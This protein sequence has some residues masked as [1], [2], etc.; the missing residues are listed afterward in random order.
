MRRDC[1]SWRKRIRELSGNTWWFKSRSNWMSISST[2][3][4]VEIGSKDTNLGQ[5]H[6]RVSF[7][8]HYSSTCPISCAAYFLAWCLRPVISWGQWWIQ[9]LYIIQLL[10]TSL[11][12]FCGKSVICWYLVWDKDL[13]FLATSRINIDKMATL[14]TYF[15][16]LSLT[17]SGII[18]KRRN[19]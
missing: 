5:S 12:G 4:D 3:I 14:S 17:V 9:K 15:M 1:S 13:Y 11:G 19:H 6:V 16:H 8:F 2:G 10:T 18:Q 7:S